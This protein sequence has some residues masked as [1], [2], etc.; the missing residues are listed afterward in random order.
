MT[1]TAPTRTYNY[2][3]TSRNNEYTGIT[4]NVFTYDK[5]CVNIAIYRKRENNDNNGRDANCKRSGSYSQTDRVYREGTLETGRVTWLQSW[6]SVAYQSRSIERIQEQT[7]QAIKIAG[8]L[9]QHNNFLA[10]RPPV[11]V[12]TTLASGL[13]ILLPCFSI[14]CKSAQCNPYRHRTGRSG[15]KSLLMTTTL[16]SILLAS[17]T[18][19]GAL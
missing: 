8:S 13:S 2:F 18:T 10:F 1:H 16:T 15:R 4:H 14:P 3:L 19:G 5:P 17:R 7:Q 6:R 12:W 9:S 11:T